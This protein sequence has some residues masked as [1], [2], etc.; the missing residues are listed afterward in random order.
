MKDISKQ[1]TKVFKNN[2]NTELFLKIL[3]TLTIIGTTLYG[4]DDLLT[5]LFDSRLGNV[6]LVVIIGFIG[7]NNIRLGI[8]TSI[9]VITIYIYYKKY[10]ITEGFEWSQSVIDKFLQ[11]QK[12]VSPRNVYDIQTLQQH[13]SE[14]ELNDYLNNGKWTWS[15]E[16]RQAY[17]TALDNNPYVR[18]YK[19]D[20]VNQA[21]K[22]YNE[23]A[24]KYILDNQQQRAIHVARPKKKEWLPSGWGSFG[25][26]A[27]LI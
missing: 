8:L 21:Q 25:Y 3:A 5:S 23:Y 6:L 10:Y 24:I 13:V 27:G 2:N 4:V 17:E 12:T 20:G 11:V 9:I 16:T 7:L 1:I 15:D 22:V 14:N 18:V 19:K 26:D